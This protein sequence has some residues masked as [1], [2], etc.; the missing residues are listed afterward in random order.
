MTLLC[1]AL[2]S[3]GTHE[4]SEKPV[5]GIHSCLNPL[6]HYLAAVKCFHLSKGTSM[7]LVL[8]HYAYLQYV[9]YLMLLTERKSIGLLL[10]SF[11]SSLISF[12]I[13]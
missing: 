3:N 4:S 13:H 10:L 1:V 12:C 8:P 9:W 5:K 11:A 6:C 2:R 7:E